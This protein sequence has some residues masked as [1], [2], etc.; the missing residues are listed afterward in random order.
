MNLIVIC[1][2]T[3][4]RDYLGCYGNPWIQTPNL[5]RFSQDAVIFDQAYG[6]G[7]PTIPARR[8]MMTGMRSFPFRNE[9]RR[10]GVPV[11]LPGWYAI[12]DEFTTLAERLR[13][14]GYT[15]G[16][17]SDLWHQ[18]DPTM[19]F[20][21]GFHSF[22][23]I[24]GQEGD[25]YR[26]GP[27]NQLDLSPY[28]KQTDG[29][30]NDA[31]LIQHLLNRQDW[32]SEEDWF[33][34]RVFRTAA[35]WLDDNVD[36][37]PFLLW[38]DCFDPHEPWDPPKEYADLYDSDY[39]GPDLIHPKNGP[40]DWLTPE[41]LERIKALYAGEITLVD[42][43]LGVL[44]EKID[45]LGLRNNTAVL[46]LADHGTALAEHGRLKKAEELLYDYDIGTPFMLRLPEGAYAHT[47]MDAFVQA[48]DVTPTLLDLA[49]AETKGMDGRSILPLITGK[50][51]KLRDHIIVGWGSFAC[52]RDREWSYMKAWQDSP[53]DPGTRLYHL[54]NDP[55]EQINVL[56]QHPEIAKKM[57]DRLDAL[58]AE[59]PR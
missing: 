20:T 57:Q 50:Q 7:E 10:P 59:G 2:D 48:H 33:P 25:R 37:N 27:R 52:V 54:A 12:P 30:T 4:R 9:P 51:E 41:E 13:E 11:G 21:R 6:E 58:M 18:F 44:L 5:D 8:S 53:R 35:R 46:F 16:L 39:T 23:W 19:N 24:R 31:I 17:V 38:V 43:W 34:A 22:E 15:T 28:V 1:V 42:K 3:W 55:E 32:I 14:H 29:S 49:G 45:A 40:I 26:S 36:N 47:R 56:D